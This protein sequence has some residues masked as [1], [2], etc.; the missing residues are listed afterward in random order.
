MARARRND[1]C[2]SSYS[3][4]G[5][6]AQ[7]AMGLLWAIDRV[8]AHGDGIFKRGARRVSALIPWAGGWLSQPGRAQGRRS[9]ASTLQSD[10]Q[11]AAAKGAIVDRDFGQC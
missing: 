7:A 11:T 2:R 1:G 10:S 9:F 8:G 4:L 5:S 6:N 3:R